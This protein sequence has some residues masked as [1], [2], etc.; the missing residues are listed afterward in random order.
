MRIII[1]LAAM[2]SFNSVAFAQQLIAR[3]LVF[4]FDS[5][6]HSQI[7]EL[8]V[9]NTWHIL[10]GHPYNDHEF[11][12]GDPSGIRPA[13]A[14]TQAMSFWFISNGYFSA[15]PE[16]SDH[17]AIMLKGQWHDDFLQGRGMI[18]LGNSPAN[19]NSLD[20]SSTFE[21]WDY[22]SPT[23]GHVWDSWQYGLQDN[24]WY[25]VTLHVNSVGIGYDIRDT[26]GTIVNAQS[27]VDI[28][29]PNLDV[30]MGG[31]FLIATNSTN[32]LKVAPTWSIQFEDLNV[33][34]F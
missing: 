22:T 19:P 31:W 33:W 6:G 32:A 3:S 26:N 15:H 8:A 25:Q 18:I 12:F 30:N 34:W 7:R 28:Y 4:N 14:T 2:F 27:G 20:V 29:Y 11:M 17:L 10:P 13:G 1:F 21:S 23:G 16:D 24:T 5:Q 9:D